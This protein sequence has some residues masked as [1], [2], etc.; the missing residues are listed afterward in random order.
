VKIDPKSIGVGQYQHDVAQHLLKD[1]LDD[2]V[3]SCVNQVGVNLN[4]ASEHLLA[5]VAGLGPALS[6]AIVERRTSKG[7]FRSR[8]ELLEIGRFS[9]KVF[10]QCAG[11]LRIPEAPNPLDN[12]AVHP[13]RY[14]AL[15]ALAARLGKGVGELLLG[16]AA[17]VKQDA[18]FR[19]EVGDYTVADIVAEL[20]K[21]GRD[22]RPAFAPFQYR[23]DA[24]ELKDLKPGMICPGIVTNVTSFGAFVDVGVHQDGLVHLSQLGEAFVKDP[25][26]VVHP[27]MRVSVRV[28]EVNLEKK[29]IALSMKIPRER[30][31]ERPRP[32]ERPPRPERPRPK[33]VAARPPAPPAAATA[34]APRPRPAP[35][36]KPRPATPPPRVPR[37]SFNN[38]FAVLADLKKTLKDK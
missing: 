25:S 7:L 34:P 20:E 6:K 17:I 2:V 1:S 15:E 37:P 18:A 5:R 21:P 13:E 23:E 3:E 29:Q 16:G 4:T 12:T 8:Q 26:R 38:P 27:G 36:P 14:A 33:L 9:K 22:P 30:P 24:R 11:F 28:L 35:P 10:E 32:S 31:R 19:A